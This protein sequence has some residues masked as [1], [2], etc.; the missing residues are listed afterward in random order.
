VRDDPA[1]RPALIVPVFRGRRATHRDGC[2]SDQRRCRS[3][4]EVARRQPDGT[5]LYGELDVSLRESAGGPKNRD[6]A[7]RIPS[8]HVQAIYAK[9]G[10]RSRAEAARAVET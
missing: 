3:C 8:R 5:W 1:A 6:P 10:V 7:K 2:R 9:L 4:A